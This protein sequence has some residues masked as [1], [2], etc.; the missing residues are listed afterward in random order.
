MVALLGIGAGAYWCCDEFLTQARARRGDVQAE[1]I[2]GK[3]CFD[4]AGTVQERAAAVHLIRLAAEQGYPQAQMGLGILY[5]KG[6]GVARDYVEGLKWLQAAAAQN[7]AVAQNELGVMSATGW[8]MRQDLDAALAWCT[9]AAQ[10]GSRVAVKNVALIQAARRNHGRQNVQAYANMQIQKVETDGVVVAFEPSKG[11]VGFA[12]IKT[13]SL[14]DE[15]KALCGYT[16][17][18]PSKLS[19]FLHLGSGSSIL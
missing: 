11:G 17:K 8:G 7:Y 15:L 4:R 2:Y 5:L 19:A 18:A 14:P 6:S 10:Q 16:A 1:Y 9:K 3:R 13:A 12:K